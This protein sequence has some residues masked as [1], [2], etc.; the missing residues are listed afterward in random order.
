MTASHSSFSDDERERLRAALGEY[1]AHFDL[2]PQQLANRVAEATGFSLD[3]DAGRKRIERFLKGTHRQSDDFV[4]AIA[5]YLGN[6]PPPE[7]EQMAATLAHFFARQLPRPVKID[8][9]RGRYR[10]WIGTDRR[11]ESYYGISHVMT[12]DGTTFRPMPTKPMKVD[13]AY[14]VI[15]MRPFAKSDA[16]MVSEAIVNYSLEGTI[17][18]FPEQL[19]P[20]QDTGIIVPFGY[21][22]RAVPRYLMIT[23]T[24]LE[25]R[26]YRLYR[27]ADDPLTLRGELYF[28]GAISRPD[29][30]TH[31][32]PLH[33][34]YGVELVKIDDA[35]EG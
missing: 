33:A 18:D 4:G 32:D 34:D 1:A 3:F 21:S 19:P 35:E 29:K 23:R 2:S 11:P 26:L 12:L 24:M 8:E 20:L 15:T 16:L 6:V 17:N 10:A 30:L 31:S 9:L 27:V 28:G 13:I 25:T 14:A 7:I 5:A 22:D